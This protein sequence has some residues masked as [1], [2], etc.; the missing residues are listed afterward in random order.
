[1]GIPA[2]RRMEI[3]DEIA[4]LGKQQ[5]K[6]ARGIVSTGRRSPKGEV[7]YDER[8]KRIAELALELAGLD[9]PPAT[10]KRG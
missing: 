7:S 2:K 9:E 10:L 8:A 4:R 6:T 3:L 5:K 1:M